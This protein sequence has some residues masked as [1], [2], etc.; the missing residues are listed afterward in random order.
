MLNPPL[1]VVKIQ[2]SFVVKLILPFHVHHCTIKSMC[3][4]VTWSTTLSMPDNL[5]MVQ[6]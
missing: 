4:K 1:A 5:L 6:D 2:V 3:K